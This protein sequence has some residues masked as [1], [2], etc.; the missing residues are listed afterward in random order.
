MKD[1][2][3]PSLSLS[4][5]FQ[6]PITNESTSIKYEYDTWKPTAPTL[7]ST[8]PIGGC[9]FSLSLIETKGTLQ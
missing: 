5:S 4:H 9:I 8:Q 2:D 3:T 6:T 1:N 7:I